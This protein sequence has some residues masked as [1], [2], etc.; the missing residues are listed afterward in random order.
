MVA[1][2]NFWFLPMCSDKIRKSLQNRVFLSSGF[3][4]CLFPVL[5]QTTDPHLVDLHLVQ[6]HPRPRERPRPPTRVVS[7]M[8]S[9]SSARLS[10]RSCRLL[11]SPSSHLRCDTG[12]I[13]KYYIR[14]RE[15]ARNQA[16][17]TTRFHLIDELV[18]AFL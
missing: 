1:L 13:S 14:L 17:Y 6:P 2:Y 7:G 12:V 16:T 4:A 15:F 5:L 18:K 3:Y 10:R 11:D 9:R 8:N